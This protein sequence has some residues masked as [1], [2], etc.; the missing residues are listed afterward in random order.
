MSKHRKSWSSEDKEKIVVHPNEH[1]ISKTVWEFGVSAVSIY[2]WKAKYEQLGKEGL[3]LGYMTEQVR[4]LKL[5]RR[6]KLAIQVKDS[7]LKKVNFQR[8]KNY[9]YRL[10][11]RTRKNYTPIA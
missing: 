3:I 7:L 11:F 4:E 9:S 10:F 8:N 2:N 1:G 6:E 5:L